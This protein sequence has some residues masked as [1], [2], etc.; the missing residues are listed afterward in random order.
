MEGYGPWLRTDSGQQLLNGFSGLSLI[1]GMR[2]PLI[3]EAV[4]NQLHT[5][6]SSSLFR[7][8]HPVAEELGSR[9]SSLCYGG[10]GR[11]LLINSGAEAVEAA[12]KVARQYFALRG[13]PRRN[14]VVTFD[15][16]YHGCSQ[17]TLAMGGLYSAADRELYGAASE[18]LVTVPG[19]RPGDCPRC[20]TGP[21][22]RTCLD[23]L[24]AAVAELGPERIAAV[25]VEPVFAAGGVIAPAADF[26]DRLTTICR[27]TGALLVADESATG[28]GRTGY[29]M[30]GQRVGLRPD[31]TVM[32][33]ALSGGY[34]PLGALVAA[35]HV[36][37]P[38]ARQSAVLSHG[39][40]S[41]GS[42]L[43]AAAALAVLDIVEKEE[44]AARAHGLGA[45]LARRL[46]W[47]TGH[48]LVRSVRQTGLMTGIDIH[49]G[50]DGDRP[51]A[52]TAVRVN[53]ALLDAGVVTHVKKDRITFFPPLLINES[54]IDF[55]AHAFERAFEVLGK[56]STCQ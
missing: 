13:E 21:C 11:V 54:E 5:L 27:E 16:A 36:F 17:G 48:P 23:A 37:E 7:M 33:K 26:F 41:S 8:T 44:L 14:L 47:L 50:D 56:E 22:G 10:P 25:V 20:G 51:S 53:T 15:R 39:S 6:S 30:G 24:A 35:D 34:L 49:T 28:L 3:D 4:R 2:H 45:L 12:V 42:P 52:L 29:L 18:G 40:S 1:C 55:A 32:A 38:F 43:A 31:L 9:L 19:P 46:E